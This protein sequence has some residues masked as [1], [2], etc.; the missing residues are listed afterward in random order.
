MVALL[1]QDKQIKSSELY[2]DLNYFD[3]NQGDREL[4]GNIHD[5]LYIENVTTL[6]EDLNNIRT[7]L[8]EI[9]GRT[10]WY[11]ETPTNLLTL[12]Q[13]MAEKELQLKKLIDHE[14]LYH[15]K[16]NDETDFLFDSNGTLNKIQVH[17]EDNLREES[18]F[19]Y[20][21][22]GVLESIEKTIWDKE[23]EIYTKIL[24]KF[25]YDSEGNLVSIEN[26]LI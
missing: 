5:P 8:R 17:S 3:G 6:E 1:R 21:D 20:S 14:E 4:G 22:S 26:I 10:S 18:I 7:Q 12:Q 9:I 19:S 16:R 25:I 11:A 24:K 23:L 15:H 2:K 13:L